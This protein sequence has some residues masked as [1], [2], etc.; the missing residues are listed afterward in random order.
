MRGNVFTY[1]LLIYNGMTGN[2]ITDSLLIYNGMT[3][4]VITDS[5]FIYNYMTGYLITVSLFTENVITDSLFIS[6]HCR[7]HERNYCLF[8]LRNC[9]KING[10]NALAVY[11]EDPGSQ[12]YSVFYKKDIDNIYEIK[13]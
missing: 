11:Y 5:I 4:N 9:Y 2:E 3:E 12:W 6:K 13:A 1:S 7:C 10:R 8:I